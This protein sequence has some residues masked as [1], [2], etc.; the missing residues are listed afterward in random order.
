MSSD[1][2]KIISDF[3]NDILITFP[4]YRNIISKWWNLEPDAVNNS[5]SVLKHCTRVFKDQ[6]FNILNKNPEL[7]TDETLNT[8]FLPGII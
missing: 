3:V 2:T 8:E 7:F 6:L 1:F 4:E 5:D